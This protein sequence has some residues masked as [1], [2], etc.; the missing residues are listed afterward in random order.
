VLSAGNTTLETRTIFSQG[1]SMDSEARAQQERILRSAVLAGD[2]SAWRTLYDDN[3]DA[4]Y[5]YVLWRCG[6]QY[7]QADE[8][9]Q[10]TWLTAVRKV[11]RFDPNK[12]T[13]SA[14]LC[15]LAANVLRHHFRRHN[16]QRKREQTAKIINTTKS[17]SSQPIEDA[18]IA[19]ALDALSQRHEAVLRAKYLDG[20]TV[21]EIAAEWNETAKTIESLLSRARQAFRE[22][23]EK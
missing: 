20:L 5:A 2:E 17:Q 16:R 23:F 6:G 11:R 4:L 18:R 15:G 12:G 3:F 14:W 22:L 9:A 8:V 10:E 7:D 13:F 21:E 1:R 19:A